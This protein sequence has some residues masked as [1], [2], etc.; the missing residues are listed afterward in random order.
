MGYSLVAMVRVWGSALNKREDLA[1]C[2]VV[3]Y[4]T[5]AEVGMLTNFI[6]VLGTSLRVL[7]HHLEKKVYELQVQ[8]TLGVALLGHMVQT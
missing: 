3:V 1:A 8:V 6:D 4:L 2:F 5:L 7:I